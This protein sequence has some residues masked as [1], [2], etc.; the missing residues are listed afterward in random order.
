MDPRGNWLTGASRFKSLSFTYKYEP[1][2]EDEDMSFSLK[3]EHSYHSVT[4][5]SPGYLDVEITRSDISAHPDYISMAVCL[6]KSLNNNKII[7]F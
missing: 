6:F 3:F 5:I 7:L 2:A 4:F 1:G